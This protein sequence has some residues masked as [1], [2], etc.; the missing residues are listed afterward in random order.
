MVSI[1]VQKAWQ[2]VNFVQRRGAGWRTQRAGL[3]IGLSHK[4]GR[5]NMLLRGAPIMPFSSNEAGR[6]PGES[7]VFH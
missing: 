1:N 4:V 3:E 5:G 7:L 2:W 6:Q